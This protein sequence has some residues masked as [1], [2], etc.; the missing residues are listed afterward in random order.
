MASSVKKIGGDL[1]FH[2]VA[3]CNIHDM[4]ALLDEDE[5]DVN[6][7]NINGQSPLHYA[8]DEE[9]LAMVEILLNYGASP[10]E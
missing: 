1:L 9:H 10:N 6:C 3:H 7:K 5:A 2:A 4:V 8:V